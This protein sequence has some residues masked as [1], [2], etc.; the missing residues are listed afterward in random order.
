MK[1]PIVIFVIAILLLLF[2]CLIYGSIYEPDFW[3]RLAG[4]PRTECPEGTTRIAN[5]YDDAGN[6]ECSKDAEATKTYKLY[7]GEISLATNP[8]L[9]QTADNPEGFSITDPIPRCAEG[10]SYVTMPDGE[11]GCTP[12]PCYVREGMDLSECFKKMKEEGI[13]K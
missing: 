4:E 8:P 3:Q 10:E 11:L 12:N 13:L 2:G 1:N 7:D 6:V 5:R 9:V